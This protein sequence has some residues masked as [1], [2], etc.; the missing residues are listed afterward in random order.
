MDGLSGVDLSP[1]SKLRR[2]ENLKSQAPSTIRY[3]PT[4]RD[5]WESMLQC[6]VAAFA[7]V[8]RHNAGV[9]G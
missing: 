3:V 4:P 7:T 8:D 6:R 9:H 5:S 2:T 1:Y